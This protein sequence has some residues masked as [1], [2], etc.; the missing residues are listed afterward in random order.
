MDNNEYLDFLNLRTKEDVAKYLGGSLKHLSYV[1]YVLPPEKQYQAI[2]IPKKNGDVRR[3]FSPIS[4]IKLYQKSLLDILSIYYKPKSST[5]GF[6]KGRSIKTNAKVHCHKKWVINIDIKDFFPSIHFGRVRGIFRA[7]P[8]EFNDVV[9]TTLAQICCFNALLPQGAPT[10]PIIS[11]FVCRKLDNDFL[12]FAKKNKLIYTRYADD[13]TLSSNLPNIPEV[14]GK[15]DKAKGFILSEQ[16]IKIIQNN[17]FTVNESKTRISFQDNRQEVT[18][19]V[20]N[21]FVNINR[22]YIRN[23]R[24]MLH[25]WERYGLK[26]AAH[27]YFKKYSNKKEPDYPEAAFQ[28]ILIGKIAYIGQIKGIDNR[29]YIKLYSKIKSLSPT[30]RLTIPTNINNIEK[31]N[32]VVFCEGKTDG[33][34]LSKALRYFVDHGEFVNL[35]LYF[36]R[37]PDDSRISNTHLLKYCESSHIRVQKKLTICLFDC[38][39]PQMLSKCKEG[40]HLYKN[41]GNNVVSCLLPIPPHRQF[42]EICIE[43]FYTDQVLLSKDVKGRRIYFSNEFDDEGHHCTEDLTLRKKTDAKCKYPKIIDNG[44]FKPNGDNVSLSKNDFAN[45][46]EKE[47][48]NFQNLSFENFRPIFELLQEIILKH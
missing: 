40:N 44:V 22:Y 9:S 15:Y 38:D 43:H 23:I 45:H 7:K 26:D 11:N 27:E 21:K 42:K 24:A 14:I 36:Y 13:I 18:G 33:I 34:H 2:S 46:I 5:H 39:E 12:T 1:F 8:F 32:A 19:L 17:D 37:Y 20:V 47:D 28:K 29:I 41:W 30:L 31:Y 35:G 6:V 48:Q 16:I 25:A 4:S 10:S 3:I